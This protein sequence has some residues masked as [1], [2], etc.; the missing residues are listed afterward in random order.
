MIWLLG[1][2]MWLYIHRPFEFWKVLGTLQIERVYMAGVLLFWLMHSGKRWVANRLHGVFL[3]F[4]AA[5][6]LCWFSSPF[7]SELGAKVWDDHWKV[8][9][10]YVLLLST[11]RDEKG[12]RL[13]L[14]LYLASLGL[15]MAHSLLEFLNGRMEYRMR[16]SRMIGV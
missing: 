4:T 5:L 1:G 10:L 15:Y 7:P 9:V 3:V 12:L 6:L 2:Y 14:K 16:T 8:G 11:V 13:V